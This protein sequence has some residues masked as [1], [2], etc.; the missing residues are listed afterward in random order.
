MLKGFLAGLKNHLLPQGEGWLILSDLAEHLE[1]RS[2]QELLSWI[3]DAGLVVLDR[4]DTKPKHPKAFD[5][6]D[7]LHFARAAE[8]TSLWRLG[9]K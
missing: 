8:I 7:P 6:S 5:E 9:I 1:L 2:R 4:I 3:E